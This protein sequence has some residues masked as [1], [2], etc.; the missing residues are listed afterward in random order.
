MTIQNLLDVSPTKFINVLFPNGLRDINLNNTHIGT[1]GDLEEALHII[2]TDVETL[3]VNVVPQGVKRVILVN[4][5]METMCKLVTPKNAATLNILEN[6]KE[7]YPNLYL[8]FEE[9]YWR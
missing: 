5:L 2:K 7:D 1:E 3:Y 4:T 6:F 9:Y 8:T